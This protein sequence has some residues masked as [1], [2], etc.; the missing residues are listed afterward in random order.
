MKIKDRE[1]FLPLKNGLI[2]PV[3]KDGKLE[4]GM[5][6][7]YKQYETEVEPIT[8]VFDSRI[9]KLI[10]SIEKP[11]PTPGAYGKRIRIDSTGTSSTGLKEVTLRDQPR[12]FWQEVSHFVRVGR[13]PEKGA[14]T[15]MM[16][17]NGLLQAVKAN[18]NPQTGRILRKTIREI[19][20]EDVSIPRNYHVKEHWDR[21]IFFK[22]LFPEQ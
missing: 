19:A 21:E 15:I 22:K 4:P 5:V 6:N 14:V 9:K 18:F 8:S 17:V 20:K 2:L 11:D 7:M 12:Y 13:T 1:K 16:E 10:K 3:K